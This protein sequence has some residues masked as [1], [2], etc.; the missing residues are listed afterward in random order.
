MPAASNPTTFI[1]A[2]VFAAVGT[3]TGAQTYDTVILNGR[4]MDP[5]TNFDAV[6]NVGISGGW[7]VEITDQPIEG[8]ETIDASGHVVALLCAALVS[9][10]VGNGDFG[11]N[12][13]CKDIS[14]PVCPHIG[15]PPPFSMCL[16]STADGFQICRP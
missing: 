12:Q 4:V 11:S 6:A 2:F 3:M 9:T 15:P 1:T 14:A 8:D 5:E 16:L 7:I 13:K 10:A